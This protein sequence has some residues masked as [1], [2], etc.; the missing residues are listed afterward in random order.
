MSTSFKGPITFGPEINS[1]LYPYR[2]GIGMFPSAEFFTFFDDFIASEET[3]ELTYGGWLSTTGDAGY[4][5][6]NGDAHG[7][8]IV[9]SSDGTTEGQSF[10]LPKCIKLTGKKFF[11]EVRVKTTD[12]DDTDVKFGLTDL[13]ASTNP[14]DLWDT[15]NADGIACGV[16]DGSAALTIVYDKNNGGPVTDTAASGVLADATYAVLGLW[17]NGGTTPGDSSLKLFKDGVEVVAATTEAQ[18]PEDVVLAP[19]FGAR[20]GGDATH[21]VNFDY[22]RFSVER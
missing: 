8:E 5:I 20:T 1:K 4:T 10:Y 18:I 14:E 13:S 16:T 6:A 22:F 2:A 9:I 17:Y 12:A 21:T 19:F 3:N 7:G 15:S 11:M